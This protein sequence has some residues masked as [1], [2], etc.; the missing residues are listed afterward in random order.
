MKTNGYTTARNP[1]DETK[2]YFNLNLF[3]SKFQLQH[4]MN[5]RLKNP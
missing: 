5:N 3:N 2:I 4:N 1:A